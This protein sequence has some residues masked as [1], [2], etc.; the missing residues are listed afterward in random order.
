METGMANSVQ[1]DKKSAISDNAATQKEIP[2]TRISILAVE[3]C[4][5]SSVTGTLDILT[6]AGFEWKTHHPEPAAPLFDLSIITPG[7]R[8]VICERR[9]I[10]RSCQ[11]PHPGK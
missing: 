10:G 3:N 7:G 9:Q 2:M 11:M 1:I 5:H 6:V 4:M 8:P